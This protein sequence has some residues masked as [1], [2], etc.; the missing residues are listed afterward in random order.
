MSEDH[1]ECFVIEC[2]V[3]RTDYFQKKKK[4]V[5]GLVSEKSNMFPKISEMIVSD[6]I[7]GAHMSKIARLL[8]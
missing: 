1:Y 6:Q 2:I 7:I 8:V 5:N 3:R 4:E